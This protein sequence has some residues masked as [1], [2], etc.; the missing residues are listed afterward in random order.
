MAS[1]TKFSV[2][3]AKR[4]ANCKKCRQQLPKGVIYTVILFILLLE[5]LVNAA[6]VFLC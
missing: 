1:S 6:F 2:D 5:Y 3:Y 4:V